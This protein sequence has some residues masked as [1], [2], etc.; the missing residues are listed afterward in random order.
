MRLYA[1][2][3]IEDAT[4]WVDVD[5]VSILDNVLR[6]KTR[7]RQSEG[8]HLNDLEDLH[9]GATTQTRIYTVSSINGER[10]WIDVNSVKV[11]NDGFGYYVEGDIPVNE[12]FKDFIYVEVCGTP[13]YVEEEK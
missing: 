3:K 12:S 13:V 4:L 7:G 2:S 10:E 6:Y 9:L 8:V 11:F 1:K 5:R